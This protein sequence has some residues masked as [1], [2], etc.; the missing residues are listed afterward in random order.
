MEQ[1]ETR[2]MIVISA[3]KFGG[4]VGIFT[5]IGPNV[6]IGREHAICWPSTTYLFRKCVWLY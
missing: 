3:F 2:Y 5:Y 1:S 4:R 6:Y